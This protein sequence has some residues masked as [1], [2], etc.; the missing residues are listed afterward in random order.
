MAHVRRLLTPEQKRRQKA[1]ALPASEKPKGL[2]QATVRHPSGRRWSNS[3]PLKRVVETWA[4]DEEAKLRRGEFIDP[5]AGKITLNDWW[6][7]WSAIRRV[8]DATR[9]KN[10]SQWRVHV[11]PE[12][13]SWPLAVIKS[14]DVEKWV[15]DMGEREVGPTTVAASLNLLTN[16]LNTAVKHQVIGSNP[17]SLVS[18][19]TVPKHKDR[20]LTRAEADTLLERFTGTDR[21]FVQLMLETGL[22]WEE[23]AALDGRHVNFLKKTVTVEQALARNGKVKVPKSAAGYRDVPLTDDL[24]ERFSRHI[25]DLDRPV[26]LAPPPRVAKRQRASRADPNKTP[27]VRRPLEEQRLNYTNWLKRVWNPAVK[28]VPAT[29]TR[30]AIP[31]AGLADPQPTPHDCRHTFASWL[32]E[33]NMSPQDLAALLGH[34]DWRMVQRYVHASGSRFDK[35]RTALE[36]RESGKAPDHHGTP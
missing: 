10:L 20:F 34:S 18:A 35:A 22:R 31:G 32:G 14:W 11:Q 33:D 23:A 36:R 25:R 15:T 12:F 24:V 3:D 19:P 4:A 29:K 27:R 9:R 6:D 2:W 1:G 13:G 8:E 16:I 21:L 7:K 5:N 28:G 26:F 17:A 30:P